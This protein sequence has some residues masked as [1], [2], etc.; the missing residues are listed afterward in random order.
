MIDYFLQG[1]F[2]NIEITKVA[3]LHK[4]DSKVKFSETLTTD[5]FG[6]RSIDKVSPISLKQAYTKLLRF[7][8]SDFYITIDVNKTN[9]Y[10]HSFLLSEISDYEYLFLN[11][12]SKFDKKDD[13][14]AY[15]FNNSIVSIIDEIKHAEIKD[16]S[17]ISRF[18]RKIPNDTKRYILTFQFIKDNKFVLNLLH[19]PETLP[20]DIYS[21]KKF[22][23]K[24]SKEILDFIIN[25]S[26]MDYI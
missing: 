13:F 19:F 17:Y 21:C 18:I 15:K 22:N 5:L 20:I 1:A 8:K 24:T 26:P 23:V 25:L 7:N 16:I 14:I 11:I 10:I 6:K 9:V 4:S 12:A 3:I 2:E